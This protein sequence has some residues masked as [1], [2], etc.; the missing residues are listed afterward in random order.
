MSK[1]DWP[2]KAND[3]TL[4]GQ[5]LGKYT[6]DL[7]SLTI[8]EL[9]EKESEREHYQLSEWVLALANYFSDLYGEDE[10]ETIT[11]RIVASLMIN[12]HPI[13]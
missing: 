1:Q 6:D 9:S 2:T 11:K 12:G 13:H 10:G 3:L 8:F 7:Q 4:A 5:I